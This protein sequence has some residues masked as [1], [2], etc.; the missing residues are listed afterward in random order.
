MAVKG[1]EDLKPV[2]LIYGEEDLLLERALHRLRG[3]IAEVADL[4]F[5]YD[6]F[7][8]ETADPGDIIAAA[9][10]LPF[11]SERRLV[12]VHN[13]DK[14]KAAGQAALAA[15][16]A[17]PSP[18]SCLVLVAGKLRKDSKLL[19]AVAAIGGAAEYKAPRRHEYPRWVVDLFAERGRALALDAAETLVRSVGRDLRRLEIEADKIIAFAGERTGITRED[20]TSVVAETAP[21]SVFEFLD[22][23]GARECGRAL[24]LLDDLIRGGEEVIRVH[25]M[26]VRHVRMLISVGALLERESDRATMMRE[27]GM[28]DWQA[29]N[30]IP[31]ARRFEPGELSAALTAAAEVDAR[32]KSGQGDP[33]LLFE[34]W[35]VELCRSADS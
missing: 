29:K 10:T 5:N 27:V 33:R 30:L 23:V 24:E 26:A 6:A 16:A 18:M 4:T 28:S 3:R 34:R 31:Q 13:V 25:A 35:L 12:V 9:N 8:G 15:Y 11:A 20:V 7:E 22:A 32:M 21:V 1:L 17:D 19:K 2:Y 14:M